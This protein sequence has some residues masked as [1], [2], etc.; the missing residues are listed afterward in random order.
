MTDGERQRGIKIT[1]RYFDM[2]FETL[3]TNIKNPNTL[4][5]CRISIEYYS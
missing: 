3:G 4:N 5:E 1:A 2:P